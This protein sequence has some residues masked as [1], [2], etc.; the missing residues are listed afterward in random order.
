MECIRTGVCE[1]P[2]PFRTPA[3]GMHFVSILVSLM[4]HMTMVS[5]NRFSDP[6]SHLLVFLVS[7]YQV[8]ST[9]KTSYH[10]HYLLSLNISLLMCNSI[11]LWLQDGLLKIK[12]RVKRWSTQNRNNDHSVCII[13]PKIRGKS[14]ALKYA[15][16]LKI[17]VKDFQH[18]GN[19]S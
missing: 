16:P 18:T 11:R 4:T 10:T 19:F 7:L 15:L 9:A 5:G 13:Y 2:L 8:K 17:T 1:H 12:I 3:Y 6:E 14:T